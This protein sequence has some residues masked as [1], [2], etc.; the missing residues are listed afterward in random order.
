MLKRLFENK[1]KVVFG[2]ERHN[3][4][5]EQDNATNSVGVILFW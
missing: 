3:R 4:D 1:K 5:G 2:Q